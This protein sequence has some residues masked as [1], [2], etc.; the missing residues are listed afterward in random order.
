M[1]NH[2]V[3]RLR[4]GADV[5]HRRGVAKV[6]DGQPALVVQVIAQPRHHRS[7]PA[8]PMHD[9]HHVL[10]HRGQLLLSPNLIE[11]PQTRLEIP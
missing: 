2:A 11:P 1:P 9:D 6:D 5:E 4:V 3:E 10:R 8:E 7:I